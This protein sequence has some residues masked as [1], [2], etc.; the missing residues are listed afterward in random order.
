MSHAYEIEIKSLLG[1]KDRAERLRAKLRERFPHVSLASR[2]QEWNHYF[3]APGDVSTLK[4]ALWPHLT[5]EKRRSLEHILHVGK[6][7]S[8]RTRKANDRVLVVLKASID[9]GTS[10]NTVSRMEFEAEV[11]GM[12]L[13]ALDELLLK[14][15]LSYQAKWSRE[16]EEYRAPDFTVTIDKNAGYGYLA[17]FEKVVQNESDAGRARDEMYA[18]MKEL[19]A[20]ELP[21]ER[22]ERMFAYYNEHWPEYYGTEKT[23][24]V[25]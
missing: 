19:G 16:R 17:E 15:G 4:E 10:A 23:F 7:L 1:S 22:L 5:E 11:K 21:Q 9:E 24:T 14:A 12:S 20:E 6:S 18:L 13:E 2:H 8:V 3:N 25:E